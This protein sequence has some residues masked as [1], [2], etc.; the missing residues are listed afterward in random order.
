MKKKNN[1]NYHNS[2]GDFSY[3]YIAMHQYLGSKIEI[4]KMLN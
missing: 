3:V 1:L 2:Y 4:Q